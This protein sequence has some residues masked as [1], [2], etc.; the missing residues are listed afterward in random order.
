MSALTRLMD[1]VFRKPH[2]A[3]Q[4]VKANSEALERLKR[5]IDECPL[6]AALDDVASPFPRNRK[7][8]RHHG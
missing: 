1:A 7:E 6:P 5:A 3:K 4:A 2:K 8:R